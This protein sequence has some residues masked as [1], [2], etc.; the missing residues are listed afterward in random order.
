MKND[1]QKSQIHYFN[2]DFFSVSQVL[3]E[4]GESFTDTFAKTP[5][6]KV[7]FMTRPFKQLTMFWPQP[8][9][10]ALTVCLGSQEFCSFLTQHKLEGK[11]KLVS[12]MGKSGECLSINTVNMSY[13]I[14]YNKATMANK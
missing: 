13:K 3:L 9:F 2:N 7:Y 14:W 4:S 12:A 6:V 8:R 11:Q 5:K 10:A 1:V